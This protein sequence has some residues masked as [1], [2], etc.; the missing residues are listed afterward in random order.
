[1]LFCITNFI[2]TSVILSLIIS[3]LIIIYKW[4]SFKRQWSWVL[5]SPNT[6]V[7]NCV[8]SHF[9]AYFY[10]VH[11]ED[12]FYKVHYEDHLCSFVILEEFCYNAPIILFD[13][14]SIICLLFW[15]SNNCDKDE[16]QTGIFTLFIISRSQPAF[17]NAITSFSQLK[18]VSQ[19]GQDLVFIL[20]F[21]LTIK[22]TCSWSFIHSHF[23]CKNLCA[24][25]TDYLIIFE[26]C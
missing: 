17:T 3:L 6:L 4:P 19:L 11:Y 12:H 16:V 24:V 7:I 21:F 26:I 20:L 9:L 1:M 14:T 22:A 8:S 5:Q 15:S 25:C 2:A 18:W 13:A 23:L 10:K